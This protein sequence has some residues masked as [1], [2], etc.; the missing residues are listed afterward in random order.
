[1]RLL[2][3][4][5]KEI[6]ESRK[7]FGTYG[8]TIFLVLFVINLVGAI[9]AKA[10]GS[11]NVENYYGM[12]PGFLMLGGA[13]MTSIFFSDDMFSKKGQHAWL[14]TPASSLEK[15]LSKAVINAFVY[16]IA[17]ILLFTAASAFTELIALA[18]TGD[19]FIMFN[20]FNGS[21][22]TLVLHFLV[23]QSIF[24]LGGTY[25]RSV[26]FI[27]TILAVGSLSILF[28]I[29]VALVSRIVFAP[30]FTGFFTP[31]FDSI[32]VNFQAFESNMRIFSIIGK[33]FYWALI[34]PFCWYVYT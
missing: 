32:T 28:A 13:I 22:W 3:L 26:H 34:A 4:L 6:H 16:P 30:Y 14:M 25:F 12:F 8:I 9:V 1:M 15:F 18:I 11:I 20:P 23:V 2:H 21:V 31:N 33:I 19:K 10:T 24:L 5:N 17:L 29:F 27:K 7:A